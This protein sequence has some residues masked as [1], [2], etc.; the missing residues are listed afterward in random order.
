MI[1]KEEERQGD[2]MDQIA[3]D[4]VT[5]HDLTHLHKATIM[6]V[7]DEALNLEIIQLHLE[8]AGYSRFILLDQS[9]EAMNAILQETPDILLLDLMMPEVT[10]F[11]ILQ[12][13]RANDKL[14]YVPVII[15]TSSSDPDD[16]LRALE[17]GATDFLSKPVDASELLLRVRN[18]L[19]VKAYQDQLA[20]YDALTG[21]PNRRLF[22]DRTC[23]AIEQAERGSHMTALLH[24]SLDRIKEIDDT[25]GPRAGKTLIQDVA[26]KIQERVRK[27]DVISNS[28]KEQEEGLVARVADGEFSILLPKIQNSDNASIAANRLLEIVTQGFTVENN[29]IVLS[30][31][32]GISI[33]PDD[34]NTAERLLSTAVNA[35]AQAKLR[36]RN[37]YQFYS[38]EINARNVEK[39][40]LESHLREAIEKDQLEL[41]YQPKICPLT[42]NVLGMEALV[43][44]HHPQLGMIQP[45]TFIP[46]AEETGLIASIGEWV[47]KE[48]CRQTRAWQ[49]EGL[50]SLSISVNVSGEQFR[51]QNL[52]K[53][54]QSAL[55]S[56]GL[57]P[58]YLVIEVTESTIMG[59]LERSLDLLNDL[60][61]LGVSLSIDD[62]GTGYSSLS[63][64]KRFPLDELKIDQ[65]FINQVHDSKEDAAIVEAIIA[66]AKA[67]DLKI[68]AEGVE[69][70]A[71]FSFLRQRG[72]DEIQGFLFSKPLPTDQFV[73]FVTQ[74]QAKT[75]TG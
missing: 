20:Y 72:C 18:T 61:S 4:A 70:S 7:D 16:K 58:R 56:A 10:G 13:M 43:R 29:N 30:A 26:G 1:N 51:L 59:D 60:K 66:L 12:Y 53:V 54:V 41:H 25:F 33:Y 39:L 62:F 48:A 46:L 34:G 68:V 19:T 75:A 27:A 57:D 35:S 49:L 8:E 47:I 44:W 40:K 21:L 24:V 55:N 63:Y 45:N 3:N 5:E 32:V 28:G 42:K 73:S 14:K 22:L 6:M 65:S 71:Q 9:T 52:K 2:D 23:W 69:T 38:S 50:D 37:C 64:L 36:G 11:Q 17:L 15:L 74:E 31:N 67:L